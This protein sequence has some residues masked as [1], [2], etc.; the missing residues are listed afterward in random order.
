[1][2]EQRP[3]QVLGRWRIVEIEGWDTDYID[4]LGPGHIQPDRDGG[5]IEFGAVQ[6]GLDCWY[7]P[8]GVHFNFQGNDEMTEVSGDGDADLEPDGSLT[9]EIRFHH[10]DEMPFIAR[11]WSI[12]ATC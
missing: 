7:S 6:V 4:M 5:H 3:S 1:M 12:S 10:G 2:T 11:R 8:T 9:G